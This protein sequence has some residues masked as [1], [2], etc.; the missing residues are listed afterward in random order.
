LAVHSRTT[1]SIHGRNPAQAR[2]D[3]GVRALRESLDPAFPRELGSKDA[4][5][6]LP[7]SPSAPARH[8]RPARLGELE[9][10]ITPPGPVDLDTARRYAD[11]GVHRLAIQPLSR[12]GSGAED[13]IKS[14]GETLADRS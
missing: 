3:Q 2:A 7:A 1:K 8:D 13:L 11:L 10:T 4:S 9:I 14:A 6:P 12:E 5:S